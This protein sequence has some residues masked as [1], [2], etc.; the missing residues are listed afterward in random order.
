MAEALEIRVLR[1]GRLESRHEVHGVT[2]GAG[3]REVTRHG[4]PGLQAYWRS[5]MK[6]FQALPLVEDGVTRSRSMSAEELALCCASHVGSREH[7]EGV[8]RLLRRLDLDE[9]DLACGSHRPFDGDEADRILRD[10]GS[11]G[12]LHNNCSGK[13]VGML[14]LA[15]HH[16]WDPRGY[17]DLEHPVQARI[18]EGLATWIDR[19]AESLAWGVDGC[20]VPTPYLS[21]EEMAEAY[22]R[23]GRAARRGEDAPAA[24]VGAMTA[25]PTLV[26]GAG[27]PVTRLMEATGGRVLAKEGAEGVFCLAVPGKGLGMAVKV[28]DGARRATAPAVLRLLTD[29]GVLRSVEEDALAQLRSVP[30]HNTRGEAVGRI[31]TSEAPTKAAR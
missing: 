7:V 19:P 27:R 16:G 29:A 6:P 26:S 5:S 21:L 23:L 17:Q 20:G 25:H 1:G 15:L 8:R 14:A 12:R 9:D 13:H 24:V 2:A 31:V 10:G 4:D 22:A 11:Y 3:G 30:I 18:R 28:A